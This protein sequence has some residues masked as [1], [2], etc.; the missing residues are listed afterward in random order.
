MFFLLVT[1]LSRSPRG[2]AYIG[3][4]IESEALEVVGVINGWVIGWSFIGV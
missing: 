3:Y 1:R 2:L 4:K